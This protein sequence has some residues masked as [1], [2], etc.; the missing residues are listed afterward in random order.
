[1]PLSRHFYS[2]NE[3]CA[4]L[5]YCCIERK[6]TEA[7]FWLYELIQSDEAELGAQTMIEVYLMRY[8][9]R[10]LSW[11]N[12][13]FDLMQADVINNQKLLT[14]CYQ[15]CRVEQQ[16][17]SLLSLALVNMN[18]MKQDYP[19]MRLHN[20]VGAAGGLTPI[21]KYFV[22]AIMARNPRAALWAAPRCRSE[23]IIDVVTSA[24]P[25]S[26]QFQKAFYAAKN[27]NTWSGLTY[28]PLVSLIM[29]LMIVCVDPAAQARSAV[30]Q[31]PMPETCMNKIN[32]WAAL[33]G[34]RAR[35]A[36]VIPRDALYL[37]CRRG[38]LPYTEDTYKE[39][40]QLGA[41]AHKTYEVMHGCKFWY[42][43]WD[44]ASADFEEAYEIIGQFA[45]P[46]DI[47]DEWSAEDQKKSHGQGINNPGEQL[48][49]RRWMQK[50]MRSSDP[51][52]Y[53]ES[54]NY[55]IAEA[56][57][58]YNIEQ[59]KLTQGWGISQHLEDIEQRIIYLSRAVALCDAEELSVVPKAMGNF[60]TAL[61]KLKM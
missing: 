28:C 36:Y 38:L 43:R 8:G 11:F 5:S 33:E 61:S 47:P 16:D 12:D 26:E 51:K 37:V 18:D 45:F 20:D 59:Y 53:L 21:E 40:R 42:D 27:L 32:E 3:V 22:G 48:Y 41:G 19:P 7:L 9:I 13:M 58:Q 25:A 60:I 31:A 50:W 15:L 24:A 44:T 1:M 46:D 35:R 54:C 34:R 30:V 57:E 14:L 55:T 10:Y 52:Y 6:T 49:W 39:L 17:A 29:C 56:I 4:A 23:V 2:L